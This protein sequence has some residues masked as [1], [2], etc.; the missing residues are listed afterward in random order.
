MERLTLCLRNLG[1]HAWRTRIILLIAL[2]GAFL[3]F[4]FENLI[5]DIS[6]KQS[7]MFG[8][9]FSGHFLVLDREIETKNSFGF[10]FYKPEQMMSPAEV[11]RVRMSSPA[12]RK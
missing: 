8:R 10:Y 2:L 1:R 11:S 6:R 5:E 4:M 3:T 7:D 9:A 12:C